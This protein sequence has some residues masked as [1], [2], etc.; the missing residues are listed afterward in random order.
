MA[1]DL[2]SPDL[3]TKVYN[4]CEYLKKEDLFEIFKYSLDITFFESMENYL[5]SNNLLF[6]PKE[7]RIMLLA[8]ILRLITEPALCDLYAENTPKIASAIYVMPKHIRADYFLLILNYY[9]NYLCGI[10]TK[11][12]FFFKLFK[13]IAVV[14]YWSNLTFEQTFTTAIDFNHFAAI[15]VNSLP[16]KNTN[17][18]FNF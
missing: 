1:L 9:C 3:P 15:V 4:L 2:K 8:H 7:Q 16:N 18:N 6:L 17:V 13:S 10:N 12:L 14:N 11:Y 5:K